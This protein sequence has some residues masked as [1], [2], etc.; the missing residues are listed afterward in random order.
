MGNCM[1]YNVNKLVCLHILNR[2]KRD[3]K[4]SEIRGSAAQGRL[5]QSRWP[6]KDPSKPVR[7]VARFLRAHLPESHSRGAAAP[8]RPAP[9][10]TACQLTRQMTHASAGRTTIRSN[11]SDACFQHFLFICLHRRIPLS[12]TSDDLNWLAREQ[13]FASY[14]SG[15]ASGSDLFY[16]RLRRKEVMEVSGESWRA[17]YS[18]AE[19]PLSAATSAVLGAVADDGQ[20]QPIEYYKLPPL[21][22][23]THLNLHKDAKLVDVWPR[24]WLEAAHIDKDAQ[25]LSRVIVGTRPTRSVQ[26]APLLL[27]HTFKIITNAL[28]RPHPYARSVSE[29]VCMLIVQRQCIVS[30]TSL[31]AH[32]EVGRTRGA[33]AHRH[34]SRVSPLRRAGGALKA[35]NGAHG[36]ELAELSGLLHAGLVKREPEDLSRKVVDEPEH[37]LKPPRHKVAVGEPGEAASPSP[38]PSR[39]SSAGSLLPDAAMYAA[40]MFAPP[41]TPSPTPYGDQYSRQPATFAGEPYY[42]EYFVGEGYQQRAAPPYADAEPASASAFSDRYAT[43]RYHSKSVIAAAGLTVDL[44]SPDSGIGADAVTPRDHASAVQQSF[45]YTVICQQPGVGE[46]GRGTPSAHHSPAQAPRTRPWHDFGRQN[47]ADK[48]QIAKL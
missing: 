5:D 41:G 2:G 28:S 29:C 35:A 12:V 6:R 48:I 27:I 25:D 38:A 18:S 26:R 24:M 40:Q 3:R 4:R 17:Y 21:G 13:G 33:R 31:R 44:P 16:I 7:F 14:P 15:S 42:R 39:A 10:A 20:G 46:D 30:M 8:L 36:A 11:P 23:D 32:G 37:A 19:H 22:Q 9:C 43:P 34:Q 45:D 47:D 1:A